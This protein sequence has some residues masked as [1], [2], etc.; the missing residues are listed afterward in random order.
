MLLFGGVFLY[1][2][3]GMPF[4]YEPNR[5]KDQARIISEAVIKYADNK[6]YNF[7]LISGGNS[8]HAYRYYLDIL[9]HPPAMLENPILDPERKS[10]TDQLLIVCEDITCQPLGHPLFDVAAFGRATVASEYTVSV[11]KIYKLVPFKEE[12]KNN[13]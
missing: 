13:E 11:V 10:V 12:Q 4:R 2:L 6:P 1:N 8:D 5:Q 7:A 3:T 9:G